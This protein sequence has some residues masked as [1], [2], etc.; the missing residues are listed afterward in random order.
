MKTNIA[1]DL[2]RLHADYQQLEQVLV[3]FYLNALDAMPRGGTLA[4]SAAVQD[5][6]GDA[7]L[8]IAVS[9]TG[10]GIEKEALARIFSRST[11]Q[12]RRAVWVSVCQSVNE[13][14]KTTAGAS[15]SRARWAKARPL[16]SFY[17]CL[18]ISFSLRQRAS[19]RSYPSAMRDRFVRT[20]RANSLRF[21]TICCP[22]RRCPGSEIRNMIRSSFRAS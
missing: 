1:A 5:A 11:R 22:M 17:P 10:V 8:V 18:E 21:R 3:N 13:S 4:V 12:R 7:S 6:N 16:K 2:P 20:K 19:N 14:S 15:K 9:D